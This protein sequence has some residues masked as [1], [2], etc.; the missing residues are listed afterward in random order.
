MSSSELLFWRNRNQNDK[1]NE[2]LL[3]NNNKIRIIQRLFLIYFARNFL[4]R[5]T[6]RWNFLL[7]VMEGSPARGREEK[8]KLTHIQIRCNWLNFYSFLSF[9]LSFQTNVSE[10]SSLPLQGFKGSVKEGNKMLPFS[11]F[12]NVGTFFLPYQKH[13]K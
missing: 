13:L 4:S 8:K 2:N 7:K 1:H 12:N 11:L 5:E 9:L 3:K 6:D 10:D